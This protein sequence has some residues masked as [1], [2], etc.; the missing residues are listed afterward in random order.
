MKFS[1]GVSELD[2]SSQLAG[3]GGLRLRTDSCV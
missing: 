1:Q 3:Q 2:M